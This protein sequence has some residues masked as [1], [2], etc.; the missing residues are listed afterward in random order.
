MNCDSSISP[1]II[2]YTGMAVIFNNHL[3]DDGYLYSILFG[4]EEI[5]I[6]PD[7]LERMAKIGV[8]T[9]RGILET[10][11]DEPTMTLRK[12]VTSKGV[13]YATVHRVLRDAL[14]EIRNRQEKSKRMCD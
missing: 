1:E 11:M 3:N 6:T 12:V 2:S 14:N 5:P 13:G 9:F 10:D 8:R 7:Y 4:G